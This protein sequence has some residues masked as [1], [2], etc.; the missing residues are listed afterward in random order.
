LNV[1]SPEWNILGVCGTLKKKW[2]VPF[3]YCLCPFFISLNFRRATL[4]KI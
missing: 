2:Y 4:M 1:N 3:P